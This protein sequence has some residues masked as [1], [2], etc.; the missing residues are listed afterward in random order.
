V[1]DAL[2]ITQLDVTG[3]AE[4]ENLSQTL[5]TQ[6]AELV[7]AGRLTE[8]VEIQ[9]A[10]GM[11]ERRVTAWHFQTLRQAIKVYPGLDRMSP[12]SV[13]AADVLN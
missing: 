7:V 6:G 5:R 8:I 11:D 1:L 2:T 9:R 3:Y 10:R 4:I 12:D 13:E